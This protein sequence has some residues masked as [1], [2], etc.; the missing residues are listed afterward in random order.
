MTKKKT[1]KKKLTE[2]QKAIYATLH[3]RIS[4]KGITV[5]ELDALENEIVQTAARGDIIPA[6]CGFLIYLCEGEKRR[7]EE[8]EEK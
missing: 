3:S 1:T 6:Q 4:E 2:A 8:E 5:K 7:I